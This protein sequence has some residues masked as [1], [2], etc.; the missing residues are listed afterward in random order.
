M[1]RVIVVG[2]GIAGLTAALTASADAAVTLITKSTLGMSNTRFAQGGIAGVMFDDDSVDAH[3]ADTLAAGAGLC[4]EDA[5]R[6][7]CAEGPERIRELVNLGVEFDR[8]GPAFARGRE[9]AHS[10][11]RVLHAGGDAT[12]AVIEAALVERLRSS[13]VTVLERTFLRDLVLSNGAI[14]GVELQGADGVVFQLDADAVL[15]ATGGAGQLYPYTTNPLV[16]TGDGA[17]AALRAGAVMADLEFYQFHPTALVTS[18]NFLISE[19]VRGDG[20][21]LRDAAGN[22]FMPSVHPNAELAPRDV[23]A[24]GIAATMALQGGRPVELDATAL[25]ADFLASRFPGIDAAVRA[26]GIDWS[27]E[28]V[29]VAPAAHY[30][31]G[32]I[33]TDRNGRTSIP[34]L[35]AIGEVARTGVHGANRL[36][37][38]SLLEGAVFGHR[39]AVA[40]RGDLAQPAHFDGAVSLAELSGTSN[41]EPIES[42]PEFSREALQHLLWTSA[43]LHRN[44]EALT[45]AFSVLDAWSSLDLPANTEYELENRNL[46]ALGRA[47][48]AAALARTESRG[49]HTR[50]DFPHLDPA[51][52]HPT[53]LTDAAPAHSPASSRKVL[54]PC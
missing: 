22:R 1:N 33:A 45:S 51:E 43:G 47:L 49:A 13:S 32:G 4:D 46:L 44:A 8:E 31:M 15:L 3:V 53:L 17:A 28:G 38:N 14:A 30:W 6:I 54:S 24:R 42:V 36:A 20:A 27:K 16:A 26:A 11:P 10:Y 39:A 41:D 9:A 18:G 19:A 12:G 40:L 34:G 23:V 35:F 50:T 37:S 7:L 48:A 29:P 2:S 25:G 5:V 21:V 52:A